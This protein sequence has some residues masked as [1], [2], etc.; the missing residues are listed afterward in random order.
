MTFKED[1]GFAL[2]RFEYFYDDEYVVDWMWVEEGE[3]PADYLKND[4]YVAG[5]DY[6]PATL[7]EQKLY[8][9]AYNDGVG[10]GTAE[11]LMER[12]IGV[13]FKFN[14]ASAEGPSIDTT[15]IFTC[16]ECKRTGLEFETDAATT[17]EYYV[18]KDI[19]N[20]LWHLCWKCTYN[21]RHDWTHFSKDL[22]ACGSMHEYCDTCNEALDCLLDDPYAESPYKMKKRDN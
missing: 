9:E 8:T 17:G 7:D 12:N 20:V 11:I 4:A 21:C 2:H 1:K 10:V 22:C 15:K 13:Y 18:C 16:G 3:D 6:R 14:S 19:E 5:V